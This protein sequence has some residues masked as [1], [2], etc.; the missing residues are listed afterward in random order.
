ML[1]VRSVNKVRID[2]KF[3]VNHFSITISFRINV[4]DHFQIIMSKPATGGPKPRGP[5][6]QDEDEDGM[7]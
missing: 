4:T 3:S 2:C 1:T 6:P 7:A 5:K